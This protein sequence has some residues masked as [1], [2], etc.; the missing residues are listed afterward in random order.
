MNLLRDLE[1]KSH[2]ALF[3][4]LL[5]IIY[6]CR[7]QVFTSMRAEA[8]SILP[9]RFGGRIG[10]FVLPAKKRNNKLEH[11]DITPNVTQVA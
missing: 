7:D 2:W 6:N 9:R 1:K 11:K 4:H 3:L 10:G 5:F 8:K